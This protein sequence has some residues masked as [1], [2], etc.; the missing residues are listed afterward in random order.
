[1]SNKRHDSSGVKEC[2][3]YSSLSSEEGSETKQDKPKTT[4]PEG[5][6][7]ECSKVSANVRQQ[8]NKTELQGKVIDR[9]SEM[10]CLG[11][12]A[13]NLKRNDGRN[14][15]QALYPSLNHTILVEVGS[16]WKEPLQPFKKRTPSSAWNTDYVKMPYSDHN[17]YEKHSLGGMRTHHVSRWEIIKKALRKERFKG[18]EEVEEAIKKY[19]KKY[20][21]Q[22]SFC[23]LYKYFYSLSQ[24]EKNDLLYRTLPFMASLALQLPEVCPSPIPLLRQGQK[25]TLTMSQEQIACLLANAFFCTFPRRNATDPSSEYGNYP[26][27]NF[28]RLFEDSTEQKV[29]KIKTIIW[30]FTAISK[31][32]PNGLV[33]FERRR[34][35]KQINWKASTAKFTKLHVTCEG[36]IEEQGAGMLQVDFAS[37][38]VGGGVLGTGLVQEEIRFLIN[39]ELIVTRLFTEK[40]QNDECLV[41]TGAQQYSKYSGYSD[42]FEW[43]GP[44]EDK[45]PRDKWRRLCTEIVAIDALKFSSYQEQF[46]DSV[47]DRELKKAFCGFRSDSPPGLTAVATGNWGCGAFKG[48]AKFKA[49]IQLMAAA[50]AQRDVMYFTYGDKS[51]MVELYEMHNFLQK[52]HLTVGNLFCLMENYCHSYDKLTSRADIYN[53]IYCYG[54]KL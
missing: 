19:N 51:L 4:Q 22:W 18:I 25:H 36:T 12:D 30:Y 13:F 10:I 40:L 20:E 26:D 28:S 45:T 53:Y 6:R 50:E 33:T 9:Y 14:E 2:L 46:K 3:Q 54:P 7:A 44:Y 16:L 21:K 39:T 1:M 47:L 27:I 48:D 8:T 49:L 31:K 35:K 32:M 38:R 17:S 24:K 52:Q 37:S 11:E 15:L 23:G 41:I 42:T 29:Q 5:V 34:L 43:A